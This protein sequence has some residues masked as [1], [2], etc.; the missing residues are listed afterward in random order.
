M[1]EESTIDVKQIAEDL[2]GKALKVSNN[3][4]AEKVYWQGVAAGIMD[5]WNAL[6]QRASTS[7]PEQNNAS[8]ASEDNQP[9]V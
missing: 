4:E 3:H 2:A 9:S 1:G 8:T 7:A 5:L 6:R